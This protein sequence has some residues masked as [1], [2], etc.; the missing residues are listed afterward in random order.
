MHCLTK[1]FLCQFHHPLLSLALLNG[2]ARSQACLY[3]WSTHRAGVILSGNRKRMVRPS[4][5]DRSHR[6]LVA[7]QTGGT[8]GERGEDASQ[9]GLARASGACL[10][11]RIGVPQAVAPGGLCEG[12]RV[13]ASLCSLVAHPCRGGLADT[14]RSPS[15]GEA[16]VQHD[17]F[18]SA[19]NHADSP[20]P[21]GPCVCVA[22]T[23]HLSIC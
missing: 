21:A 12:Q 15:A 16:L 7:C 14:H 6:S 23:F 3:P 8:D 10:S 19:C 13:C 22:A 1:I 4:K 18:L 9:T 5:R 2:A 11:H 17:P 20:A